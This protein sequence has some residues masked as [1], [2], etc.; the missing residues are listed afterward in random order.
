MKLFI[1]GDNLFYP[2]RNHTKFVADTCKTYL[3]IAFTYPVKC[4]QVFVRKLEVP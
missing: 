1:L 4:V 2:I 3:V